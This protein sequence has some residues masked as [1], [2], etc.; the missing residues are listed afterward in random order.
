[1]CI[2]SLPTT[3]GEEIAENS[4]MLFGCLNNALLCSTTRAARS[5]R[6]HCRP[7]NFAHL[8]FA[9]VRTLWLPVPKPSRIGLWWIKP[10]LFSQA[11]VKMLIQDRLRKHCAYLRLENIVVRSH[12]SNAHPPRFRLHRKT[13]PEIPCDLCPWNSQGT[14]R[15]EISSSN[16][17][18]FL[19]DW[20]HPRQ[21]PGTFSL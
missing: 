15:F 1:M 5:A 3:A 12:L 16:F 20:A 14:E 4:W 19:W 17:Q 10:D 6:N 11:E 7:L 8:H 2:G 21:N 13:F 18:R 9:H